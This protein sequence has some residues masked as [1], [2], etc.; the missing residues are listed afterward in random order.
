M[1]K[2]GALIPFPVYVWMRLAMEGKGQAL[3]LPLSPRALSS[4]G[5]RT[6][7]TI[8]HVA[9][10]GKAAGLLLV[11]EVFYLSRLL[12]VTLHS[13]NLQVWAINTAESACAWAEEHRTGINKDIRTHSHT[14]TH[15][16]KLMHRFNHLLMYIQARG[17][18]HLYTEINRHRRRQPRLT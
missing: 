9:S 4:R 11:R 6:P 16:F 14:H 10:Q 17:H 18:Q 2:W 12:L 3:D 5:W 7:Q 13:N 15:I 1:L 8:K